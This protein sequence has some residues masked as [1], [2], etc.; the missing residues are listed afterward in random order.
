MR[1]GRLVPRGYFRNPY[2]FGRAK[3]GVRVARMDQWVRSAIGAVHWHEETGRNNTAGTGFGTGTGNGSGFD[4]GFGC[5]TG[6]GFGTGTG[7]GFFGIGSGSWHW[8]W[9]W[10]WYWQWQ[11]LLTLELTKDARPRCTISPGRI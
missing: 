6:F 9:L 4:S 5:G 3:G 8:L 2:S 11:W 7:F 1:S 10:I